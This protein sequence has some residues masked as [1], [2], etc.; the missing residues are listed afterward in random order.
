MQCVRTN[1]DDDDI[2][3]LFHNGANPFVTN[4]E[5]KDVIT[6]ARENGA[7]VVAHPTTD[8]IRTVSQNR[9][10]QGAI[11]RSH[12]WNMQTPQAMKLDI[13]D[14]AFAHAR[15]HDFLGTDDVS[16][17]EEIGGDVVVVSASQYN[18]KVTTPLDLLLAEAVLAH[19][20]QNT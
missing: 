13:A 14:A 16:L 4:E 12:L 18:F 20:K 9:F 5:I 11:D 6:T 3:V 2:V 10:S 19:T 8:T 17:V 7:A 1:Y 15:E